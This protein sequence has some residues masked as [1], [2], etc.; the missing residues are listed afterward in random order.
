MVRA[1]TTQAKTASRPSKLPATSRIMPI[2]VS[3]PVASPRTRRTIGCGMPLPTI[4][5]HPTALS[6]D[7]SQ[8]PALRPARPAGSESG[9]GQRL[10]AGAAHPDVLAGRGQLRQPLDD[11]AE[12]VARH[13]ALVTV[14][15]QIVP[16]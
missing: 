10:A 14:D 6:A 1:T 4:A 11:R 12:D 8:I 15:Q 13:P 2:R 9:E 5:A 7:L 3:A 16:A